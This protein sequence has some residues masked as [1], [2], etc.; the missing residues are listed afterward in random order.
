MIILMILLL[1]A[2]FVI[3]VKGADIFVEGSAAL[4]RR[5]RVPGVL[6][7]LTI[8]ALGTSAPE[9]AVSTSAAI[10]GANEIALSNVIGSNIF[11]LLC[12]LGVCAIIHAVPVDDEILKRDFPLSILATLFLLVAVGGGALVS[13]RLFSMNMSEQAGIVSRVIGGIL[14]ISFLIYIVYLILQAKKH[15]VEEK[16][17]LSNKEKDFPIWKCV[18]F[19]LLGIG[20][21]IGGGQ[22]VV[23]SA[24]AIALAAGMTETLVGLTIVA[25]GTSLPELVTSVVA[26]RKKETGLAVGNA[27]GSCIFNLMFI[28]GISSLINP[29]GANLA[30]VID[31]CILL[32]ISV[33]TYVF[34][35]TGKKIR[36]GE[37]AIL[38]CVY[39]A[40]VIFAVLR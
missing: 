13:G 39:I 31:L 36:R 34:A 24:R 5:F 11:N 14:F 9:L 8:V 35:K 1:I 33:L 18:L 19:I 17:E 38:L 29:V 3:L 15:P 23:Y 25:V 7:G 30:S 4:A 26:A 20:M 2:G 40:D 27:V 10:Q 22:A 6:I 32:G 28:L 12:V 16:Q 37:G 21:I